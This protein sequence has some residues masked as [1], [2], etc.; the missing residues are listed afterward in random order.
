MARMVGEVVDVE[1]RGIVLPVGSEVAVLQAELDIKD[2][3]YFCV[4]LCGY[5]EIVP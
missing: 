2:V 1:R 4:H 5:F 3:S